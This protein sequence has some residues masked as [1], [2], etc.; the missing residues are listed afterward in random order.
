VPKQDARLYIAKANAQRGVEQVHPGKAFVP[1]DND[2]IMRY[3]QSPALTRPIAHLTYNW[4]MDA[5]PTRQTSFARVVSPP[6]PVIDACSAQAGWAAE[7]A[8]EFGLCTEAR[9]T[10]ECVVSGAPPVACGVC[11]A[12]FALGAPYTDV[13]RTL[14][15]AA[16]TWPH[17][18]DTCVSDCAEFTPRHLL[19]FVQAQLLP[20]EVVCS[21]FATTTPEPPDSAATTHWLATNGALRSEGDTAIW[22]VGPPAWRSS[23][24][25][26]FAETAGDGAASVMGGTLYF[27]AAYEPHF[28]FRADQLTDLGGA[29]VPPTPEGCAHACALSVGKM[30]LAGFQHGAL[31][32]TCRCTVHDPLAA[33]ERALVVHTPD[34]DEVLYSAFW[35][36]GDLRCAG[37]GSAPPKPDLG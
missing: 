6:Q 19:H 9:F 15:D 25:P 5:A 16:T 29:Q 36:E 8:L 28:T 4:K 31:A 7:A 35:C 32:G 10:A 14:P 21:C 27:E 23:F 1:G 20:T 26:T 13:W 3:I 22:A 11:S 37:R 30:E 24:E 2:E 12:C 17:W 18:R 33:H 34:S